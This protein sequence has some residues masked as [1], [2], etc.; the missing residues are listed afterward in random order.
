MVTV[1]NLIKNLE[2][3]GINF[4]C[5][6][7]DSVLSKLLLYLDK[8]KLKK[9]LICANEGGAIGLAIGNYLSSGKISC[10]YM[11]NSGLGNAINPIVSIA[12]SKIYSIPMLLT[13]GWRGAP[14]TKDEPQHLKQGFITKDLLKLLNIRYIEIKN[15]KS[16]VKI[17]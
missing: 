6:V 11:Q 3:N 14:N 8:Y 10:V 5:G 17:S 12:H 13:I 16:L 15:D 4:F 2:K 7:P 9:H 1:E